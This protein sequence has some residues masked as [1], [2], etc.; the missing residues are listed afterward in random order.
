MRRRLHQNATGLFKVEVTVSGEVRHQA[1]YTK[2][3]LAATC[4]L[5]PPLIQRKFIG[6]L[7]DFIPIGIFPTKPFESKE[8]TLWNPMKFLWNASSH[9][10]FGGILT[11]GALKVQLMPPVVVFQKV[12]CKLAAAKKNC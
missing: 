4:P 10:S 8:L 9:T 7:E 2:C 12:K 11:R 1:H 6:I 5:R 3:K